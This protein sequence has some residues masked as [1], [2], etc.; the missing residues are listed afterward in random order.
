MATIDF[1]KF[2]CPD[3]IREA[4]IGTKT[5]L[6]RANHL[7]LERKYRAID[8]LLACVEAGHVSD[9]GGRTIRWLNSMTRGGA[10]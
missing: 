5:A 1:S 4:F 2:E 3:D 9:P 8:F 6:M 7:P 10:H